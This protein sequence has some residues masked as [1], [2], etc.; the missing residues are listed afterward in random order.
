MKKITIICMLAGLISLLSACDSWLDVKPYDSMTEEQLYST[1][2]G[3]QKALNGLY[4]RLASGNLYAKEMT[5]GTVDVLAQRFY[6]KST[7]NPYYD[8]VNYRYTN[9]EPKAKFENIWKEAYRL[10]ADCNEFLQMMPGHRSLLSRRDYPVMMGEA[11]AVRTYV[12]FDLFRL[13]GPVYNA[14]N[15]PWPSIPYYDC[16]TEEPTPILPA[17]SVM[18]LL[19]ADIDTAIVWMAKDPVRTDGLGDKDGFWDYR[20]LRMNYYA[21]WALKAR[22]LWYMGSEYNTEAHE[23]VTALLEGKDP[24][25]GNANNFTEIFK[26]V[27]GQNVA[28]DRVFFQEILFG[29][30]NM[31]RD[32][33]YKKLFSADLDDKSILWVTQSYSSGM[34]TQENDYRNKWFENASADR[35]EVKVFMKFWPEGEMKGNTYGHETQA[36]IRLSE[37]L[38]IAASTTDDPAQKT[39]YLEQLRINRGHQSGNASGLDPEKLLDEEYQREF[40]GE[41][42]YF[43]FLKRNQVTTIK[44]Q[45]GNNVTMSNHYII[46]LP[47]SEINNRYN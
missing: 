33:L 14:A 29:I 7:E 12:H 15:K 32:D 20:N 3:I 16:V 11:L 40:Y 47:D 44:N 36:L 27:S 30:H 35:G 2:Q 25:T 6:I 17:E 28:R 31:N 46:P 9:D 23:I 8:M 10:I 42:Q 5:C 19:I 43:F 45:E 4:L 24:G 38:L 34:Y 37:L 41:G 13:F 18:K 1:E 26:A 39:S 22:M 21:A